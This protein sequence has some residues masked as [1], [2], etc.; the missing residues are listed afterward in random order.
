MIT[1][2]IDWGAWT[3]KWTTAKW[4]AKALWYSY[5]DTGAMYRWV[6]LAVLEM[7]I[8]PTNEHEVVSIAQWLT[9]SYIYAIETDNFDILINWINKEKEV[10]AQAVADIVS[11]TSQYH[12]VRSHLVKQQQQLWVKWWV[13]FDGRDWWSIIA[14]HAELKIHLLCDLEVRAHRRQEQYIRQ[15]KKISLEH[16]KKNLYERDQKDLYGPNA[17]SKIAIDAIELDTTNLS[18]EQQIDTILLLFKNIK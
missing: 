7:N 6:A 16:I 5:I 2:T 12:W 3:W 11:I 13:V 4:V 9:F 10:R 15:W 17:T 14:P 8:D 18:I 1:I